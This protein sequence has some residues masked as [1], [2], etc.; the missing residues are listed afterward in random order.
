MEELTNGKEVSQIESSIDIARDLIS[1][2]YYLELDKCDIEK[3]D[4]N[5]TSENVSDYL[6]LFK[7]E[8]FSYDK[9]ESVLEKFISVLN[10]AYSL[11]SSVVVIIKSDI[12]NTELYYGLKKNENTNDELST[13]QKTFK[14][15]INGNF[16]GLKFKGDNPLDNNSAE[17][18]LNKVFKVKEKNQFKS[19]TSISSIPSMKNEEKDGFIQGV[20]KIIEGNKGKEYSAIFIADPVSNDEIERNK[21]NMENLYTN[22]SQLSELN[23]N[24]GKN[25]SSSVAK[26]ISENISKSVS[27]STSNSENESST[28]TFGGG[29]GIVL[30]GF[31]LGATY[32][33]SKTKGKSNT[34][35]ETETDSK[36]ETTTKTDSENIGSSESYEIKIEDKTV[37]NL[38]DNIQLNLKRL[39]ESQNYGFWNFAGYIISDEYDVSMSV[40]S[41]YMSVMRGKQSH[42]EYSALNNW[43]GKN[44][45]LKNI[46]D[47]IIAFTHPN[48]KF[49]FKNG[50][51]RKINPGTLINTSEL[52]IAIGLPR[53]SVPGLPVMK[54]A[55]F[56]RNVNYT[57]EQNVDEIKEISIGK[58]YHLRQEEKEN[59]LKLN[60]NLLTSHTFITGT[61]GSGKT[62]TIIKI[63]NEAKRNNIKF[64]VIEPAK[65]EYKYLLGGSKDTKVF[66]TNPKFTQLLKI[67]P[68]SFNDNIHVLEHMDRLVEIFNACWPMYA[69]MP[70]IL[71]ESIEK[72]YIQAGWDIENSI[73]LKNG[74]FPTF[75]DL[76]EII[77]KTIE[78]S[79]YSNILKSDYMGALV[80]RVKSLTNGLFKNIFTDNEIEEKDLFDEN[81][82]IDI[83]RVGSIETKSLLMGIIFLKLKEH[84]EGNVEN[85]NSELKHITVLE[86]AHNLLK[87]TSTEFLQESSNLQGKAVEMISNSIAEMRTYGEGFIIADQS[88]GLLDKSAIR[89]TGTKIIMKL[90]EGED[91]EIV[92]KS[93]A[94]DTEQTEEIARLE[95]GVAVVYQDNWIEPV[96]CKIE[97]VEKIED[98]NKFKYEYDEKKEIAEIKT[99][100]E[101]LLR[102]LL[103]HSLKEEDKVE[104]KVKE[105]INVKSKIDK[106]N[107]NV[108]IRQEILK[109]LS[110]I[111]AK[112]KPE[113]ENTTNLKRIS[114]LCCSLID[115]A[116]VINNKS[117]Y[118]NPKVSIDQLRSNVRKIVNL[119]ENKELE[120][121]LI[122][123]IIYNSENIDREFFENNSNIL[124]HENQDH[125]LI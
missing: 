93:A 29:G 82:I 67:N 62:N 4:K 11:K 56:G 123:C 44:D 64:L 32:N 74:E 96:L 9:D 87:R 109:F 45:K 70:A 78:N 6:R 2:K 98:K 30:P 121:Q 63:L 14:K 50:D 115:T 51:E 107:L 24:I 88:P 61:T 125:R 19:I 83:S 106:L 105:V 39:E 48:F 85:F 36:G 81:C 34:K 97:L 79:L 49:K 8:R 111:E 100:K 102:M 27:K 116:W 112:E 118:L 101:T 25:Q 89:N 75:N 124:T 7:A 110:D 58:I 16:P 21:N 26:S 122:R 86:E 15:S 41:N 1:K 47:Y 46:Q 90:A 33:Y 120:T 17:E 95:K 31:F 28:H 104:I 5:S 77:P 71:K 60:L 91:R 43:N 37:K 10:V 94:L 92:G 18:L 73:N 57:T 42:I 99:L 35:T 38:Q 59:E 84:R 20:E 114:D 12:K 119:E 55:E 66:G 76:L 80:T 13:I 40:A 113:L 108:K 3:I 68:F 69:A 65:G 117:V 103:N 72:A 23:I 52:A 53:K 22:I 54:M